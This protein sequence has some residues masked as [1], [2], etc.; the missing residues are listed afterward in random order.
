MRLLGTQVEHS[1]GMTAERMARL[2]A[3]GLACR[4]RHGT[5]V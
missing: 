4:D 2:V 5:I 3:L 1:K